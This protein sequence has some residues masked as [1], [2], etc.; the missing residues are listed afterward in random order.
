MINRLPVFAAAAAVTLSGCSAITGGSARPVAQP[1]PATAEALPALLLTA[2]EVGAALGG[3]P[4]AVAREVDAPWD[5]SIS[6]QAL[7]DD[8]CL[9]VSGAA[10]RAV[11]DGT[12]WTALRGQVLREPPTAPGWS[13]FASQAVVLF[14]DPGAAGHFFERSVGA[15]SGCSDRTLT[16]AQP[17]APDQQWSIGPVAADGDLLTV[18]R[19][20]SSPMQWFCQRALTVRGAVA[21]DI[22]ACSADGPTTAA[23]TMARTIG[24]RLPNP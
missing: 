11:Y 23:A 3:D 16:Y 2:D 14:G 9:A 22:E 8:G 12:G 19:T 15:W 7:A 6:R 18:S 10:Q 17:M 20:Q 24:E 21:I 4:V 5:D 1:P 13:H